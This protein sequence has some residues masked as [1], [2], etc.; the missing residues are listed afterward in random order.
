[1]LW[2][3]LLSFIDPAIKTP[4]DGM[5]WA[6]ETITTVGYGDIVPITFTGRILA[7]MLMVM[8]IALISL[9]TANFSAYFI[10]KENQS[11][12]NNEKEM[13]KILQEMETKIASI[14]KDLQAIKQRKSID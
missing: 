7:I 12:K 2:G 10:D 6:W 5:W 1:M 13:L 9:L 4:W 3:V 11:I 14:Q 8:G